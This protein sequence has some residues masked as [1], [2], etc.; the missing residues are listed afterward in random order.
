[1]SGAESADDGK[2]VGQVGLSR[3]DEKSYQELWLT[4]ARRDWASMALVPVDQGGS[5]ERVAHALAE[6]GRRL[7]QDPVTA[8]SPNALE[9]GTAMALADIPSFVGRHRL[10]GTNGW[11]TVDLSRAEVHESTAEEEE[12]PEPNQATQALAVRSTARLVISLPPVVSEPLGLATT[13][14]VDMVLVCL[15]LGRTRLADARRT[16]K[17]I[18][19]EQV[20]G[21]LL[22]G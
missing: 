16:L 9:Y 13:Q 21:C 17:L 8:I 18:G 6:V 4:L 11:P 1:M 10:A 7:S 19:R 3:E 22:L 2:A 5:V 14:T 12:D 15:E 20:A